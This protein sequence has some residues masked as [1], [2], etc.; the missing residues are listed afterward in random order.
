MM[1]PSPVGGTQG[2]WMGWLEEL[3][4][5]KLVSRVQGRKSWLGRGSQVGGC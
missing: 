1:L 4:A 3:G 2:L 5:T